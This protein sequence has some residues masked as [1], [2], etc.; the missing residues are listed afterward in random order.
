VRKDVAL[1]SST[2]LATLFFLLRCLV[3][4]Q[5]EIAFC[6]ASCLFVFFFFFSTIAKLQSNLTVTTTKAKRGI[7]LKA[8][9]GQWKVSE[10]KKRNEKKWLLLV[11]V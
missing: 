4:T 7:N 1:T 9:S 3:Q 8:R 10:K 5:Y 6:F 2:A 11:M